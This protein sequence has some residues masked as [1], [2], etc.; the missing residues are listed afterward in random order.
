MHIR[1]H[2]PF[3]VLGI[4]F[5]VVIGYFA[6]QSASSR[7]LS[8]SDTEPVFDAVEEVNGTQEALHPRL[9]GLEDWE[10]P[11]GPFKV[12][13]QAGHWKAVE[14]PDEQEQ[15]RK[16][17]GAQGG[18]MSEWEVNVAIAEAARDI[19]EAKGVVVEILPTTI[20]PNYWADVFVAIHADGNLDHSIRGFKAAAPRRDYSGN[21]PVLT[22]MLEDSYGSV[23]GIPRDPQ[24]TRNMRG[25]YAFNWRRYDHSLHPLTAA[26]IIETGF[27][28]NI[29]DRRIIVDQPRLAAQGIADGILRF[30]KILSLDQNYN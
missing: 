11:P 1:T 4:L 24:V 29:S 13:L 21:S 7:T 27:L 22:K 12:A 10:R 8:V 17:T 6:W 15:L 5:L 19:L 26:S 28:T 30:I 3:L 25:Y 20:P 23:S 16:N 2:A 18:G 9:Q 14:A